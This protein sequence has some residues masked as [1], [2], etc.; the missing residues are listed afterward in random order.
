M[1]GCGVP[2]SRTNKSRQIRGDLSEQNVAVRL[3]RHDEWLFPLTSDVWHQ[4]T[5]GLGQLSAFLEGRNSDGSAPIP[6]VRETTIERKVR[7]IA[8]LQR[9]H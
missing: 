4:S 2:V 8:D 6:V 5:A 7:P 9:G 1:P 3:S